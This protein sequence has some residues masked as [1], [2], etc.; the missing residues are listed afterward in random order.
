MTGDERVRHC[1]SCDKNVY[2]ISSMSN[3][4]AKRFLNVAA[5]SACVRF[6]KRFDG[7]ILLDNCPIGL[8]KLRARY[9]KIAAA[10]GLFIS[11][12]QGIFLTVFAGEQADSGSS[13]EHNKQVSNESHRTSPVMGSLLHTP[14]Y[15]IQAGPN[16]S[17]DAEVNYRESVVPFI[18]DALPKNTDLGKATVYLFVSREGQI[19]K[20]EFGQ[21]SPNQETDHIILDSLKNVKLPPLPKE[22]YRPPLCIYYD[23]SLGRNQIKLHPIRSKPNTIE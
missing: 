19:V 21:S 15:T 12:V 11:F 14:P 17:P 4:E 6:F 13:C 3:E 1:S 10:I 8:S 16:N 23:C 7:T 20:V 5:G 2:N 18:F 9:R 22:V